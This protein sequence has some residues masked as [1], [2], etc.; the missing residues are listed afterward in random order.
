MVQS[1]VVALGLPSPY[2]RRARRGAD[3]HLHT[4]PSSLGWTDVVGGG[5]SWHSA[6]CPTRMENV[7]HINQQ[8]LATEGHLPGSAYPPSLLPDPPVCDSAYLS[9]RW[10]SPK[11]PAGLARPVSSESGT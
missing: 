10:Q 6:S 4:G 3:L 5:V 8:R 7:S 11:P 1:G 9:P 2:N